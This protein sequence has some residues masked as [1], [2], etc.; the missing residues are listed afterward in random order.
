L[1]HLSWKG[2]DS[3]DENVLLRRLLEA[4]C[5]HLESLEIETIADRTYAMPINGFTSD[6]ARSEVAIHFASLR[7]LSLSNVSFK[8]AYRRMA[9]AFRLEKLQTLRLCNCPYTLQFLDNIAKSS[10]IIRLRS[11]E[12]V[13]NESR[14][15]EVYDE[16][17]PIGQ[18]LM[19]FEGLEELYISIQNNTVGPIKPFLN[20]ILHHSRTLRRLIHHE[21]GMETYEENGDRYELTYDY[22]L[23]L[24]QGIDRALGMTA[25]ENVGFCISP[26]CLV[27]LSINFP[28][29]I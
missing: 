15:N 21:R 28:P 4:N 9:S 27:R 29:S 24:E 10:N 22:E 16:T 23:P 17:H 7:H 18:F 6:I 19:A 5:E 20:P 12:V 13:F 11:F 3:D 14:D 8:E 2:W 26:S 1:R 25:L